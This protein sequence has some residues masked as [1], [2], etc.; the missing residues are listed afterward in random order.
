MW[1]HTGVR[2]SVR[3]LEGCKQWWDAATNGAQVFL[4]LFV[5]K[6]QVREFVVPLNL[7]AS[8]IHRSLEL[9]G[10]SRNRLIYTWSTDFQPRHRANSMEEEKR[11]WKN[12]IPMWGKWTLTSTH[13]RHEF[14]II[15]LKIITDLNRK[16]RLIRFLGG[17]GIR[18]YLQ[19]C[20]VGNYLLRTQ[21]APPCFPEK[22]T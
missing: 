2:V 8:W 6:L 4:W 9:Y 3:K 14:I 21:K 7:W 5:R 1:A 13:H 15:N 11:W 10:E 22:K 19:N 18:E 16:A 12:W 20:E 17:K